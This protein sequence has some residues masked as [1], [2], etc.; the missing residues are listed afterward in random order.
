MLAL[1]STAAALLAALVLGVLTPSILHQDA[2]PGKPD[3]VAQLLPEETTAFVEFV[4]FPRLIHDWKDYVGSLTTAESKEKA[5]AAV[6]EFFTKALEIVPERLLKNLK[7]GL[8][9]IQRLAV[10]LTGP[11][12]DDLPWVFIGT[13]SD[14]AFFKKL[15][16]EDLAVFAGEEK[17][18]GGVRVFA[19]RKLG[20]L[21]LPEPLLVAAPAGK[22]V[23]STRWESV[24][25]AIDR[26]AGRGPGGDLRKNPLYAQL[27]AAPAD[28]PALRA[29]SRWDFDA[30]EGRHP[31]WPQ[32][33][34]RLY[35]DM[36][37]AT[38]GFRKLR[39]AVA[40]AAF[41]PGKVVSNFRLLVDPGC[42]I[43]DAIRQPAGP[44]ELVNSLPKKTI[45]FA[46]HNLKGG[47]EVW[48]DIETFFKRYQEAERKAFPRRGGRDEMEQFT[49]EVKRELG[50]APA[51]LAAIVGNEVAFA[52]ADPGEGKHFLEKILVLFR[53]P[54]A[55]KAR[56]LMETVAK[57]HGKYTSK[58]EDQLTLYTRDDPDKPCFGIRDTTVAFGW[59]EALVKEALTAKEA[60]EA[61]KRLT[62]DAETASGVFVFNPA[63]LLDL[64]L[65]E[66]GAGEIEL[67]ELLRP[68]DWSVNLF[69]TEKDSA[70]VT[71]TDAGYGA[72][73]QGTLAVMP[74]VG[75]GMTRTMMHRFDEAP[76]A[77]PKKV[78]PEPPAI[79]AA[80][81]EKRVKELVPLL[82]SDE[83]EV[84]QKASADLKALGR[85]ALPHLVAAYKA[86][87]DAEARSRL[88]ALLIEN[89]GWDALP[90]LLDH[91]VD[92]F[93]DEFS[94]ALSA[95]SDENPWAGYVVWNSPESPEPY[96]IEP[97]TQ[98]QYLQQ[99][100]NADVISNPVAMKRL[101]ERL[102]KSDLNA[103]RRAQVAG[104]LAFNDSGPAG[105]TILEMRDAATDAESRAFLTIALGWSDDP[106]I[107]EALY[108]SLES[109]E[110]AVRRAAFIAAERSKDPEIVS[111]LLDRLKDSNFETRWNAGYTVEVLTRRKLEL[112]AFLP[113]AEFDPQIQAAR[114][115]WDGAKA[116]FKLPASRRS[117]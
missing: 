68:D 35:M 78:E 41:K 92:A 72:L 67:L 43:F 37:D 86:E 1:K 21:K 60:S 80:E 27:A 8:P 4:K 95:K 57:T 97:Y 29:F 91:K 17:A 70:T 13:S 14:P 54:D 96:S 66:F 84:R 63:L 87:K 103:P 73:L 98:R 69:R 82:R 19:I 99:F 79:P 58:T 52:L 34:S 24:T 11:V 107:K 94:A 12:E 111:R 39:G 53:T 104:L 10:A 108:K 74:A 36:A 90:E 62:K 31:Y 93:F 47:K 75:A 48:A 61:A 100:K 101:A 76:G 40:E 81:L 112:N 46:H 102:R 116:G 26:A 114:K 105:A 113:D 88:T 115:W 50:F 109:T 20:D 5:C 6:E 2:G 7:A 25:D 22:F 85:Q 83:L 30:L 59:S 9:T 28:D 55:A 49:K 42:R 38:L 23:L 3:D 18:H 106:R 32:R 16:E 77:P 65:K 44:K 117:P 71:S 64:I 15:V 51:D 56:E 110:A 89:K 33:S 45:L